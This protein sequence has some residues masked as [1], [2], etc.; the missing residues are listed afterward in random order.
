MKEVSM[1]EKKELAPHQQRVVDEHS[2]LC[3]KINALEKFVHGNWDGTYGEIYRTLDKDERLRLVRQLSA[4]A[5]YSSILF[6]RI[7]NF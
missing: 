7:E 6:D 4:M 5:E 2:E 1:S 3:V